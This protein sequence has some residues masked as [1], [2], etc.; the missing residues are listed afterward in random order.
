MKSLNSESLKIVA[1]LYDSKPQFRQ[2][3]DRLLHD[4]VKSAVELSDRLAKFM[5]S[6]AEPSKTTT[7]KKAVKKTTSGKTRGRPK[8]SK[9]VPKTP[10][11]PVEGE[12][13]DTAEA[14]LTH[15]NAILEVLKDKAEGLTA[16]EILSAIEGSKFED[17]SNPSKATLQTTLVGL[18]GRKI[19]K[20]KG[21]RPNTKYLIK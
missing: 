1:G 20:T 14:K 6:S 7:V 13:I 18:K 3:L 21:S 19:L 5:A 8:G 16:S 15:G 11:A 10:K 4:E 12:V 9:N 17:Y 2:G